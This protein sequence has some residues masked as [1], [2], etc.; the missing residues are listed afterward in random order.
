MVS[1]LECLVH[2]RDYT[3]KLWSYYASVI[4]HALTLYYVQNYRIARKF[5][6]ELKLAV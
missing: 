1:Q 5:G 4:L 3:V 2:I 6:V